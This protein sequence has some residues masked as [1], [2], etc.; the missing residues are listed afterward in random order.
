[1]NALLKEQRVQKHIEREQKTWHI[2][3][4]K[5]MDI[6]LNYIILQSI[7]AHED[8]FLAHDGER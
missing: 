2:T 5:N 4:K 3:D 6:R 8:I 1:M 7:E